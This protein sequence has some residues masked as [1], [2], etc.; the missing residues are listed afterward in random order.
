M[1]W[2]HTTRAL[3]NGKISGANHVLWSFRTIF[4]HALRTYDLRECPTI[5]TEWFEDKPD[6]RIID[7]LKAWRPTIDDLPDPIYRIF[8]ELLLF[9]GRRKSEVLTLQ[10][11]QIQEDWIHLPM[12]K[13]C[14]SFDFPPQVLVWPSVVIDKR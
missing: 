2:K 12:T 8:Y 14:R 11:K 10:W 7:D 5:A 9:S 1:T 3:C 6:W 13:N 4:N